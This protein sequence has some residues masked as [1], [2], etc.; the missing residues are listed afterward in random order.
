M[1]VAMLSYHTC[2][3][4]A[5]GGKD[6]GGMNVY[7]RELTRSL[8]KA[9]I[10]VDVFTRSQDE[11]IPH[12]VHDLGNGNRVIHIPAGPESPLPRDRLSRYVDA[13]AEGIRQF[14]ADNAL[15][16]D[17]IHS[18][19]WLSGLAGLALKREW[20]SPLLHM[21]HTLG[22]MKNRLGGTV[23]DP[24]RRQAENAVLSGADR[25]VSATPAERM[26]LH[27]LYQADPRKVV[28]LP[29]GVDLEL[30]HPHPEAETRRRLGLPVDARMI[31]FVGR[32][33]RL[34]GLETLLRAAALL[35]ERGF[36]SPPCPCVMV[37][38]GEPD[39]PKDEMQYLQDLRKSLSLTGVVTFLGKRPQ[40]ELPMYYS[41]AQAV[42]M[43][44]QYESFGMVALE[45][46]ACG[47]PVV[48]SGVGGLLYLVRDGRTGYH[49]PDSDPNALADRLQ[50]I[51]SNERLRRELG[52]H[53]ANVAH[54]Y[55][56][57]RITDQ[58]LT[59]YESVLAGC[60]TS[61]PNMEHAH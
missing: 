6:T 12:V 44:S 57:D 2:P 1:R 30:F 58:M 55:S 21:F 37:I 45:A 3:L 23:E 14:A 28:V 60:Y 39:A 46:M 56:W 11:H 38:G 25:I 33:E 49:I 26:Q 32:I 43:P 34:K 36:L 24:A 4:A 29:P 53:A 5:L 15:A 16:Y 35:Q 40:T 51:L 59:L 10:R 54:G 18:H 17:L 7:V 61:D 20:G 48:A 27:W 13:F 22:E 50:R 19:Y 41:S 52:R 8:G 42:V 9:G 31:L 47:T